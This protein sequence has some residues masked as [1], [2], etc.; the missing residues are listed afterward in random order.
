MRN[1]FF[2]EGSSISRSP[3]R[4]A[5]NSSVRTAA[6]TQVE[7]MN[8]YVARQP[9]FDRRVDLVGYE[10]L[11]RSSLDATFASK[12]GDSATSTVL[13]NSFLLIGIEALTSGRRAFINFTRNLLLAD[14][15]LSF[16]KEQ[17]VVE[18][19]ESVEPDIHVQAA[20]R[21]LKDAGYTLALDDFAYQKKFDPLLD[22]VDIVKV[23]FRNTSEAQREEVVRRLRRKHVRFLAEKVETQAE[24]E[25]AL[26]LGYSYVQGYFFSYPDVVQG[27]DIPGFKLNYLH[28][29]REINQV[30]VD[31]DSLERIVRRDTSLSYKLLR[32]INSAYFGLRHKVKSIR[33]ALV[34]LGN[35]ELRKW[36][37]LLTLTGISDNKPNEL[38][39]LSTVRAHF[40]E[41]VAQR[42][43]LDEEHTDIYL[44]G[45]FSL[46]DAFMDL[47]MEDVLKELPLSQETNRALLGQPSRYSNIY[48][49]A[50]AY[51]AAQWDRCDDLAD[52]LRLPREAIPKLYHSALHA[53]NQIFYS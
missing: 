2:G 28:A 23:D 41:L 47:P 26:D 30:D 10:L 48:Q 9:I 46:V 5:V 35:D 13:T 1:R 43:G 15:P 32:L 24:F 39:V 38:A 22:Y 19:L 7:K 8:V 33:Q 21:R 49:L 18:I 34:L 6:H 14:I 40:C 29:L 52:Q 50:L 51:E 53:A 25:M 11:F 44:M 45:L 36:A 27:R 17:I 37:S 42:V 31:I 3:H 12:S 16:P 4:F 20:C